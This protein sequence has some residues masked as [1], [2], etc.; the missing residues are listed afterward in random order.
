AELRADLALDAAARAFGMLPVRA[1]GPGPPLRDVV[2]VHTTGRRCE[3]E[4]ARDKVLFGRWRRSGREL[5]HDLFES[6]RFLGRR[7]VASGLDAGAE[8]GVGDLM[9]V[10]PETVHADAVRRLLIRP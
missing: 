5:G 6:R 9:L 4:G 8:L 1:G 3:H 10:H 2:Q 7:D